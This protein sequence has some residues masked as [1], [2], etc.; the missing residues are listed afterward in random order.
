LALHLLLVLLCVLTFFPLFWMI[1]TAF[2]PP[3]EIFSQGLGL[4]P[5]DPTVQNFPEAF[6]R[7]PVGWWILNSLLIAGAITAGKLAIS[8]PA[9]YAFARRRFFGR[10]VLFGLVVG[11]MVVP[12]VITVIPNYI[13]VSDLYWINTPQGVIVP[14]VAFTGFYV[15]LL[16]QA[17]L[18]LPQEL[19]D[20]A[21]VDGANAWTILWRIAF[22]LV[23]PTVAVVTVLAFLSAWNLY[24][25]PFLVLSDTDAQTLAV[26]IQYFALT[27]DGGDPTWGA[28]MATATLALLPP[29]LLYVVAQ[30]AIVSAFV[31]SGVKG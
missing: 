16:R 29:L 30:R 25:W 1:S 7:Q 11:T 26:G 24:I 27:L 3:G 28:L 23:R 19:F 2:E 13:L 17:M 6:R 21:K 20:A 10:D 15:F 18:T 9:A 22:P 12:D 5:A 14:M 4:L 8:I 31:E